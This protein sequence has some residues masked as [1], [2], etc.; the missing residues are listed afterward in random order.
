VVSSPPLKL[1]DLHALGVTLTTAEALAIAQSVFESSADDACPPFGPLSAGNILL[2]IDGSVT[3]TA[4]AATPTVLEAAILLEELLTDGHAQVPGALRYTLG[5]ALHEVAAPPFD[6]LADFSSALRRFEH[7]ARAPVVRG[8]YARATAPA[9]VSETSWQGVALPFAATVLIGLA[10]IGAGET[11][12][13]SRTP[14]PV[15]AVKASLDAQPIVFN[16]PPTI[17]TVPHVVLA[18][19]APPVAAP[20]R[21]HAARRESPP[22]SRT[23]FFTRMLSRIRIRVDEL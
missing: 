19:T 18:R 22:A 13:V 14:P 11:M 8:V 10:L 23:G 5:R 6:S 17:P 9:I 21:R 4:C 16:P 20:V 15:P 1:A 2:S 12:H 3:S 7:G